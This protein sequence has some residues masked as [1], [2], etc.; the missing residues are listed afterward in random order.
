MSKKPLHL[1][2]STARIREA[3]SFLEA[4]RRDLGY[5]RKTDL[6]KATPTQRALIAVLS[7]SPE[8]LQAY[9]E[10]AQ[11]MEAAK[12]TARVR[13]SKEASGGGFSPEPPE[14]G[15]A[16]SDRS[17]LAFLIANRLVGLEDDHGH[18]GKGGWKSP[19]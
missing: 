3:E 18:G 14:V 11:V 10:A 7:L 15:I 5:G 2:L 13:R 6:S 8:T 19:S 12:A 16:L 9:L 17:E 1:P 4:L